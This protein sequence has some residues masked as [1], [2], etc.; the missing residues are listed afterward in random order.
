MVPNYR[1]P[2]SLDLAKLPTTKPSPQFNFITNVT[3]L[4][5]HHAQNLNYIKLFCINCSV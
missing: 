3:T 4:P 5:R 1:P 2:F